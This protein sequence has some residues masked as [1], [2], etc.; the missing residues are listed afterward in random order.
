VR[1]YFLHFKIVSITRSKSLF[2]IAVPE[3]K[4]KPRS[5]KSSATSPPTTPQQHN[6][7]VPISP[8]HWVAN[9]LF[10][11]LRLGVFACLACPVKPLF[12]FCLSGVKPFLLLPAQ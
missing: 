5:N 12:V 8:F 3:G 7:P 1:D 11:P 2:V 4:H 6:S 10:F 9:I